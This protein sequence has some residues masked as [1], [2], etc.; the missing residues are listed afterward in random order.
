MN[1][2][3]NHNE[4][5]F[6]VN[7]L[8]SKEIQDKL[9]KTFSCH[10]HLKCF[11]K[12]EIV[13]QMGETSKNAY[14]IE[15]GNIRL[16]TSTADG[17][18]VTLHIR[19]S[20]ECFGIVEAILNCPRVRFAETIYKKSSIWVLKGKTLND[21]IFKDIKTVYYFFYQAAQHSIRYQNIF[22][23]LATLPA[24][25]RILKLLARLSKEYGT[26][27]GKSIIIDFPLTHE[28]LANMVGISRQRTTLILNDLQKQG[29]LNIKYKK[30]VILDIKNLMESA[31]FP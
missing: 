10:G 18:E 26:V 29:V 25:T 9:Y 8:N 12:N 1:G 13:F 3:K 31:K 15:K 23:E 11:D 28:D 30:I 20:G 24:K 16:F 4:L 5:F 2:E 22:G 14:L 7:M 6:P 27:R 19:K 17:K 21:L